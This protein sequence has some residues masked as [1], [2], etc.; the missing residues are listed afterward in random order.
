MTSSQKIIF[1]YNAKSGFM[2]SMSDLFHNT[3]KPSENS[4]KLCSLTYSGAFMKKLWKEY[5]ASLNIPTVFMH[6]DEFEKAYSGYSMMYPAILL[7]SN[8]S[9][10]TLVTA[11][12]FAAMSNLTDLIN[13]LNERLKGAKQ[14]T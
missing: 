2:H 4:C 7:G 14:N 9:L 12:D 6:K 11:K 13:L 5:V 10:T 8:N 1:V 3:I